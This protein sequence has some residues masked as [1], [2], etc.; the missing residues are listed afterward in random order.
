[1]L[2][3]PVHMQDRHL[4]TP[5]ERKASET[6]KMYPVGMS[7]WSERFLK[8]FCVTASHPLRVPGA[9]RGEEGTTAH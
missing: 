1:M 4:I 5:W 7:A 6:A 2:R 9:I 8:T 3:I